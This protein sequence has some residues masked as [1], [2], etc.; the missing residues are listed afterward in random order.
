MPSFLS[1]F[2]MKMNVRKGNLPWLL[3]SV[4]EIELKIKGVSI[5][6]DLMSGQFLCTI[7]LIIFC[8]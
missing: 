4:N 1:L 5:L 6:S 8:T 2:H 3:V 7:W